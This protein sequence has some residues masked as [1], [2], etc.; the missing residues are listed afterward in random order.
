MQVLAKTSIEVEQERFGVTAITTSST[1]EEASK[2]QA[3]AL[4]IRAL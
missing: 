1:G 4:R 3:E 2:H